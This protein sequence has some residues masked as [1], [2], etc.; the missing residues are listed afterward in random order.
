MFPL[1]ISG[2]VALASAI[3]KPGSVYYGWWLL[4]GSVVAMAIGSGVSF[5]AFGLYV[6]PLE[7]D[8]GWS[9]ADV[10][11]GFSVSILVSG[12]AGPMVGKW[13]DVR[14]PRIVIII[15]A[16][17]TGL[18]YILM[19]TTDELWQWYVYQSINAVPR[20]MMFFIPFQTLI[21]RWFNRRRGVAL[22]VLGSGFS[23]GGLVV[24]PVMRFVIDNYGWEAS[25]VFSGIITTAIFVPL[26]LFLVKNSPEDVGVHADGA[27][28]VRD[29]PP[30]PPVSGATLGQALRTPLFWALA[31]ALMLFFFGMFGWLV[32]QI[33]FYESVGMSRQS[34]SLVVALAAGAGVLSRLAFAVVVD[35]VRLF[36][37]L[38]MGLGVILLAAMTTLLLDTGPVG[39]GLFLAFWVV[40][41]SAGPM[42]EALLLTRAFG[43]AHFGTIFGVLIVV[44]TVGQILSPV[45]AGKI[46]DATG[47]YDGAL[48]M[49]MGTFIGAIVLFGVAARLPRPYAS[50]S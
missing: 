17:L 47:S 18:T 22:G 29:A 40:G 14:G 28:V 15:G 46:F 26:G 37:Y 31:G 39:I 42:M 48:I 13:I 43:L 12:L 1:L 21:A 8:F 6:Q 34:A 25:F 4:A 27:P 45:V 33:P 23:L 7:D 2:A 9:R 44:E 35:R 10:S 38:A 5:W 20:Q 3:R 32:H 36:E 24:V 50:T 11:L 49:F 41:A 16:V 30:P 19:A